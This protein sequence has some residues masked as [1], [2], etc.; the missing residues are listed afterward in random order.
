MGFLALHTSEEGVETNSGF[1]AVYTPPNS[2]H[3]YHIDICVDMEIIVSRSGHGEGVEIT[4]AY[5]QHML[6]I[7]A[8]RFVYDLAF[9]SYGVGQSQMHVVR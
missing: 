1:I 3:H 4:I 7:Y 6:S 5:A 2:S 8:M 9:S